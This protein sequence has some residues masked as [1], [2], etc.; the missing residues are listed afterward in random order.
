[1]FKTILRTVQGFFLL[2]CA[3]IWIIS[4]NCVYAFAVNTYNGNIPL[5]WGIVLTTVFFVAGL[6]LSLKATQATIGLLRIDWRNIYYIL[7][8]NR[9]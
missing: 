1:M 6:I 7:F 2:A 8:A 3:A 5:F 9:G 4:F